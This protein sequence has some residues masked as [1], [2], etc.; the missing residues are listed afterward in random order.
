MRWPAPPHLLLATYCAGLCLTLA[1]RPPLAAVIVAAALA[2]AV[3]AAV[4]RIA[5]GLA[6]HGLV[7]AAAV[8]VLFV[9]AG[10]AAGAARLDALGRSALG[11]YE[12]HYVALRAEV[13]D[14]PAIKD[15]QVTLAVRVLDIDG[16]R[17]REPAHLRL[18]LG[19]GESFALDT[20]GP[21]SEGAL[22]SLPNVSVEALPQAKPGEFDYG[23]YLRRRGEHVLLS[24]DFAGLTITGRRGGVQ[25]AVDRLRLASRA[26]L[27]AGVHAPVS[28]VLQGM[29]LGDDEGVP[30]ELV[31]DFRRR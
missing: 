14:L 29:V 16:V 21:L 2:V 18:N 15:A 4:P 27:R 6:H 8:A 22:I 25:G 28:D 26:H 24:S 3:L 31:D 19:D 13:T 9:C 11:A 7:V 17:M 5:A 12:G 1:W 10:A 23:R 20:T 30:A